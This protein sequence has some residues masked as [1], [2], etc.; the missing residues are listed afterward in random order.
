MRKVLQEPEL[1][2]Q[3]IEK[4]ALVVVFAA[5]RLRDYFQSFTV[6]VMTDLPIRKVVQKP[7][8]AYRMV[9]WAVELSEFDM[10]YEPRGPIKG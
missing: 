9:H 5:P 4:A 7:D 6:I 2:Y 10:Q 1:L 8:I 3:A